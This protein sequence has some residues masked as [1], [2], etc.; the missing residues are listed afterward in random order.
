MWAKKGEQHEVPAN[1]QNGDKL[2]R[3]ERRLSQVVQ[4]RWK[5]GFTASGDRNMPPACQPHQA[6]KQGQ[7][8]EDAP[9]ADK[10]ADE[11]SRGNAEHQ[12]ATDPH[13]NDADG[14][15]FHVFRDQL[16][17]QHR[18]QKAD[19]RARHGHADAGDDK[20]CEI[21]ARCRTE[22]A[23]D[24]QA[25]STK[26]KAP[27]LDLHRKDERQGRRQGKHD[28]KN[29]RQLPGKRDRNAKLAGDI[30]DDADYDVFSGS[31]GKCRKCEQDN[32]RVHA[33][34]LPA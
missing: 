26:K 12:R 11:N 4:I 16:G 7:C 31:C 14:S 22:I 3:N 6:G 17:R 23:N 15:T 27:A 24:E 20:R 30:G 32:D 1:H 19:G 34:V 21:G 29:G 8:D 10:S 18:C 9:P 25:Q 28:R 13:E 33:P 5:G 2:A